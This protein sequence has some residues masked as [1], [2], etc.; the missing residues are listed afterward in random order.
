MRKIFKTGKI[1][2][3]KDLIALLVI[4]TVS[5]SIYIF[6]ARGLIYG[7]PVSNFISNVLF[8]VYAVSEYPLSVSEKL[9]KNYLNILSVKNDN[10]LLTAKIKIVEYR[11]DK[12]KAYKIENKKLKN[13]LFLRE[14][15]S[16]KT[17][18]ATIVLHG[19]DSWFDSLY[20]DKGEKDGVKIGDGVI[21][22]GG[23]IGRVVYEG[24]N[25]AK[26][27]PVT[28]PKCVFSVVDADTGTFGIAQGL[29]D[30]YL[31]MRF[32]FN[33]QKVNLGD[34]ILTSGL[35]GIFTSG[36][37]VGKVFLV[38]RKGYRIFQKIT[39]TPYK[40]LFNSKYVLVEE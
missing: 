33:S 1:K 2:K 31:K 4:I 20:I 11:L 10:K 16:K 23:V 18:P 7:G 34:R 5:A 6:S 12:Y 9:Y 13:L 27:I 36:I 39:I 38:K 32:V 22:Y 30:G 35:G 21:S 15:I 19:I 17:I 28:N 29:G 14:N 37:N 24:N 3:Y 8:N 26:I 25:R 40:N